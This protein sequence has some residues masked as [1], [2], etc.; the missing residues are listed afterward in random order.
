MNYAALVTAIEDY[1]AN[2][3]ATFVA[4]IPVFVKLAEQRVYNEVELP[5]LRKNSTGAVTI[6]NK[7]LTLP[8]DWLATN[9]LSVI[10]P[11]TNAQTYLI[12]KDVEYIREAYPDP[13]DTGTPAYYAQFDEDS[14]IM[15]PAPDL[16]Y[17]M[18]LHYFYYPTT[19]VTASTTWLGDNFDSVL[20]Y[21]A[22]REAYIF[23]KGEADIIAMYEQKYQE[24]LALLVKMA[25][26]R[27]RRDTY[28]NTQARVAVA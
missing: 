3:E 27:L 11:T 28:R 19:I 17:V 6:G 24:S 8:T 18:E 10:N 25:K 1:V 4:N 13:D 9:S 7:Y 26:G 12:N 15:G 14:I 16:A 20:L 21:G 23:M 5:V 22:L 2:T